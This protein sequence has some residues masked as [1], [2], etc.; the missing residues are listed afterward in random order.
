MTPWTVRVHQF[1]AQC[2]GYHLHVEYFLMVIF[3]HNTQ[4]ICLVN[5]GCFSLYKSCGSTQ[6]RQLE[7]PCTHRGVTSYFRWLLSSVAKQFMSGMFL[8]V[9]MW[10]V[11]P[12]ST[13][14]I[15]HVVCHVQNLYHIVPLIYRNR[16]YIHIL[17]HKHIY[18]NVCVCVYVEREQER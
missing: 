4:H 1:N 12:S 18:T 6:V 3:W 11:K 5:V 8:Q 9:A 7:V 13:I 14:M 17:Y 10:V 15:A 16:A 2:H